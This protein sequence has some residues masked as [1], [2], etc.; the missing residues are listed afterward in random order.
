[1]CSGMCVSKVKEIQCRKYE[2][3]A[4]SR[5]FFFTVNT[6]VWCIFGLRLNIHIYY[7]CHEKIQLHKARPRHPTDLVSFSFHQNCT[8]FCRSFITP[9]KPPSNASVCWQIPQ[10]LHRLTHVHGLNSN[11]NIN[12]TQHTTT[13]GVL[14]KKDAT[15]KRVSICQGSVF[16]PFHLGPDQNLARYTQST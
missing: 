7:W 16:D 2:W 14:S 15:L 13:K 3:R 12:E 9:S 1:M 11:E 10:Q 8:V 4:I 6:Y 5:S